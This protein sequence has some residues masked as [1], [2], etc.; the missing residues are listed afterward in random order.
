MPDIPYI[1]EVPARPFGEPAPDH[2]P[3]P[4]GPPEPF[5]IDEDRFARALED[6][7]R[8]HA[9]SLRALP[10]EH[11]FRMC[12]TLGVPDLERKLVN[13]AIAYISGEE[14]IPPKGGRRV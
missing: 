6:P 1:R 3:W 11:L 13:W 10:A 7:L 5:A 4:E 12:D 14:V 9:I 8:A 2:T